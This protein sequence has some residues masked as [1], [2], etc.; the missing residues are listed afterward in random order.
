MW[1]SPHILKFTIYFLGS[2][3]QFSQG[4]DPRPSLIWNTAFEP[5][6]L[7]IIEW[8]GYYIEVEII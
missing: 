1:A 3:G 4:F 6:E 8:C 7:F 2:G 5:S